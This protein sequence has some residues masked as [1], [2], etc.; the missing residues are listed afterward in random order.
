MNSYLYTLYGFTVKSAYKIPGIE[1]ESE[2]SLK[3]SPQ[4][5]T[6][7]NSDHINMDNVYT[8]DYVHP[9]T[10]NYYPVK[11]YDI[12]KYIYMGCGN[13]WNLFVSKNGDEIIID[14][15]SAD[16]PSALIAAIGCALSVCFIYKGLMPLHSAVVQ[17][18]DKLIGLMAPSGTGKSSLM[19]SFLE[20]GAFFVTDDVL[21][22][23][24]NDDSCIGHSSMCLN[25]K[26]H[27][28][29]I[30]A[31]DLPYDENDKISNFE[32]KYWIQIPPKK[33]LNN[34]L[35]VDF[36][37]VLQP[38]PPD[39]EEKKVRI[40]PLTKIEKINAIVANI[41]FV[42]GVPLDDRKKIIRKFSELFDTVDMFKIE[43]IKSY[44]ALDEITN[45]VNEMV[46]KGGEAWY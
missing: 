41:H 26:L 27:K 45:I 23:Q 16:I 7:I 4:D 19:W 28:E 37:F 22:I 1:S 32:E 34:K 2:L 18:N 13:D 20:K 39:S 10:L 3:D 21:P 17:T 38:Y 6:I 12:G 25:S 46:V 42:Y 5:I 43:Y 9:I 24:L 40:S 36:L 11:V 44:E 29:T 14:N 15:S 35:K 8:C 31:L 33:R 30:L